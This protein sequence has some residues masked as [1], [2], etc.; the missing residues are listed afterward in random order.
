MNWSEVRYATGLIMLLVSG[1]LAAGM[2]VIGCIEHYNNAPMLVSPRPEM[3][4]PRPKALPLLGEPPTPKPTKA[5]WSSVEIRQFLL[6]GELLAV[7]IWTESYNVPTLLPMT[8]P[9]TVV[10]EAVKAKVK[11]LLEVREELTRISEQYRI[12]L[13]RNEILTAELHRMKVEGRN[14]QARLREIQTEL[15]EMDIER[16]FD[17]RRADRL[18]AE[19]DI[20]EEDI[21]KAMLGGL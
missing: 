8:K 14:D 7:A 10:S 5:E 4:R 16:G 9:K 2:G 18:M 17:K 21:R 12:R 19:G 1:C 3:I 13:R 11:R 20:L 15:I 6:V